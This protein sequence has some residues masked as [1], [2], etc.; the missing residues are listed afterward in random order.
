MVAHFAQ[1]LHEVITGT[2]GTQKWQ[3][4]VATTGDE[5]Q[6]MLSPA[7]FQACG[8]ENVDREPALEMRQGRGT[9]TRIVTPNPCIAVV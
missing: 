9:Q 2:D 5:M 8:H 3:A 6:V 7:A 1:N 4:P